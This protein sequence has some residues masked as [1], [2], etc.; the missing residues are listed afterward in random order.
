MFVDRVDAVWSISGD[1]GISPD[2]VWSGVELG[3]SFE[4]WLDVDV[5]VA[6]F[7]DGSNATLRRPRFRSFEDRVY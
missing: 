4:L 2:Q 3:S 6:C 7:C 1:T 5:F